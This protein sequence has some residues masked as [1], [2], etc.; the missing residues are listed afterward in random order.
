MATRVGFEPAALRMQGAKITTEPQRPQVKLTIIF[1][2]IQLP[3]HYDFLISS[4][5]PNLMTRIQGHLKKKFRGGVWSLGVPFN[6][7]IFIYLFRLFLTQ[8]N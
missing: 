5:T 8:T 7:G 2:S 6:L 1:S 4:F 3:L